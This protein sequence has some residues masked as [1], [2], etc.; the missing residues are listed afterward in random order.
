MYKIIPIESGSGSQGEAV[1]NLQEVLQFLLE[2][3]ILEINEREKL[4]LERH[5]RREVEE[6]VYGETTSLLVQAFQENQGLEVTGVINEVTAEV[7]NKILKEM[8]ASGEK[9]KKQNVILGKV[10]NKNSDPLQNLIVMAYDRDMRSEELLGESITD[11]EGNYKIFW[12]HSQLRGREIKEAD[13]VLKVLT[14]KKKTLLYASDMDEIRFN[15]SPREEINITIKKTIEPEM[16]EYEHLLK[17]VSFLARDIPIIDLQ[18]DEKHQDITFLS[19][20]MN[21]APQKIEYLV[22]AHRIEA[23]TDIEPEFFYALLRKNTLLK[24]DALKPFQ[25]RLTI[26]MGSDSQTLLYDAALVES[27]IIKKDIKAAVKEM[28]ISPKL[29]KTWEGNVKLLMPYKKAAEEYYENEH[30]RKILKL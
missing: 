27:S 14:Q 20:E 16:I 8:G 5:F 7:F 2:R 18:E 30:P 3:N 4:R 9:M 29:S 15:A 23:E 25:R 17:Q 22:L 12:Q 26:D 13:I 1:A 21:V 10:T 11:K 19:K 24:N 6:N 28:I